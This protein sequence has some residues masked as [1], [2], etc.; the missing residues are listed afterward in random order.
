MTNYNII[1]N[2][3]IGISDKI[4]TQTNHHIILKESLSMTDKIDMT[5]IVQIFDAILIGMNLK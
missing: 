5:F 3:A 1:L 4:T 2:E